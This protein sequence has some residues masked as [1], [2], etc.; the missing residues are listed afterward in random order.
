VRGCAAGGPGAEGGLAVPLDEFTFNSPVMAF[1]T[2]GGLVDVNVEPAG[3]GGYEHIASRAVAYEVS[4]IRLR[5][6]ALQDAAEPSSCVTTP[7]PAVTGVEEYRIGAH[8]NYTGE[9]EGGWMMPAAKSFRLPEELTGRLAR[10]AADEAVSQT[11]LVV[12]LLDE[13]LKTRAFPGIVY[14]EGPTGRRAALAVGPDVWEVIGT[15]KHVSGSGERK[16]GNA[17]RMLSLDKHWVRL[18]I[19]FYSAF[20]DEV[21]ARIAANDEAAALLRERAARRER[22]LA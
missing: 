9:G 15:V 20:P 13:G 14:R 3:I 1:V 4:G 21:D 12:A 19:E 22:L 16:V 17:A 2:C 8:A 10:R 5:V 7:R 11:E 6:A 18:A